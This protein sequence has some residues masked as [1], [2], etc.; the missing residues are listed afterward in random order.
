V[1][2]IARWALLGTVAALAI[3]Y[4]ADYVSLRHRLA[5]QTANDPLEAITIQHT[6]AIP[7]KDGMAEIVLAPAETQTCVHSLFPHLGYSPCWYVQR[8]SQKT[9]VM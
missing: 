4:A 8:A 9:I 6:Y 1:W 7:H 3:A 5:H 2:V